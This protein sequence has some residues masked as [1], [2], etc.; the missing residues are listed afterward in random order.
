MFIKLLLLAIFGIAMA[1][2]EGVVVVY[3]RKTLGIADTESN[4]ATLNNF[5]KR[6]IF[7]EQT[8]EA[9]T[10][11]M[12]TV[13]AYLVGITWVEKIIVFLWA[14]AFWDLFYYVSLYVLIKWPPKLSTTDVLFL[15]PVPWIAPVWFPVLI[16][17][18]T[19]IVIAVLYIAAIL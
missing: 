2:L 11:I 6:L 19:I 18:L 14:F 9:A 15:I 10:I 12:L 4:K 13:I 7:I 17:S 8:R 5:P 3:L 1:H 16:S